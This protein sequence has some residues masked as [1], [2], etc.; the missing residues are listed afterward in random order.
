MYINNVFIFMFQN[1]MSWKKQ[2]KVFHTMKF[3][4]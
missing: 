2:D 3:N 1:F 4:A